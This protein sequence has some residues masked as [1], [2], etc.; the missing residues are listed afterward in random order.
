MIKSIIMKEEEEFFISLSCFMGGTI[1]FIFLFKSPFDIIMREDY[2][3]IINYIGSF[4][5][6]SAISRFFL[7]IL[8]IIFDYTEV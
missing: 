7:L 3:L 1:F 4:I 2:P 6:F 8:Q 5:L